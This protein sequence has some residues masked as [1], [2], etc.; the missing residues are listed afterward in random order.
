MKNI[1]ITNENDDYFDFEENAKKVEEIF[2]NQLNSHFKSNKNDSNNDQNEYN[3]PLSLSSISNS[4]SNKKMLSDEKIDKGKSSKSEIICDLKE[5]YSHHKLNERYY[6][7]K[8]IKESRY[9]KNTSEISNSNYSPISLNYD[10]NFKINSK[11]TQIDKFHDKIKENLNDNK[12]FLKIED[13]QQNSNLNIC[14]TPNETKTISNELHEYITNSN[15]SLSLPKLN[16]DLLNNKENDQLNTNSIYNLI[17]TTNNLTDV[18]FREDERLKVFELKLKADLKDTIFDFGIDEKIN[19]KT[20]RKFLKLKTLIK[21]FSDILPNELKPFF[22]SLMDSV[23]N[24]MDYVL[25]YY[26]LNYS[27]VFEL[28]QK[29]TEMSKLIDEK[30]SQIEK[31]TSI[32]IKS[33]NQRA[34]NLNLNSNEKKQTKEDEQNR[35]FKPNFNENNNVKKFTN[36]INEDINNR[37]DEEKYNFPLQINQI[38]NL[39]IK[40]NR[41]YNGLINLKN[42][43]N[44][45]NISSN[46]CKYKRNTLTSSFEKNKNN[47]YDKDVKDNYLI[48]TNSCN[49]TKI[50]LKNNDIFNN[51]FNFS[52]IDFRNYK[53][54]L[55]SSS[56]NNFKEKRNN[57]FTQPNVV[58]K[59]NSKSKSKS[60]SNISE[61]VNTNFI[62]SGRNKNIYL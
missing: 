4:K 54:L 34:N 42:N 24:N 61:K 10:N 5:K 41:S 14:N 6:N 30:K 46:S 11:L 18:S 12:D 22:K 9:E 49:M 43:K 56:T 57:K 27:K 32:I 28:D 8:N 7:N 21:E 58:S 53:S 13:Q 15:N 40:K 3:L 59:S 47:M 17:L 50:K 44:T 39:K 35:T 60:K 2:K 38:N 1:E 52:K 19:S 48:K 23:L 16:F 20:L 26:N 51:K 33:Q 45:I 31:L 36:T 55:V 29:I 62:S 25:I 37:Y